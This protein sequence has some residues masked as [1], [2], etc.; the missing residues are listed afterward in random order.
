MTPKSGN[1]DKTINK[2]TSISVISLNLD[3]EINKAN[4]ARDKYSKK[5]VIVIKLTD[6][7]F[8]FIGSNI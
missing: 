3:V 5:V 6:P 8:E 1:T 7:P 2:G 4:S